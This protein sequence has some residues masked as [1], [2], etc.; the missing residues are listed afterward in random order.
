[1]GRRPRNAASDIS[2][3]SGHLLTSASA[4]RTVDCWRRFAAPTVGVDW[5]TARKI[6]NFYLVC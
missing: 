3:L 5:R 6:F 2:G 4:A 1:M